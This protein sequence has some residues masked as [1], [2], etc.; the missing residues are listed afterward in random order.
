MIKLKYH[1][2]IALYIP[3]C[4]HFSRVRLCKPMDCS[5]PGS[6]THWILQARTLE[7]DAMPSS[8]ES[9]QPRDRTLISWVACTAGWIL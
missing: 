3:L 6:S 8:G 1:H 4:S 2:C 5:P 9:S 7:W